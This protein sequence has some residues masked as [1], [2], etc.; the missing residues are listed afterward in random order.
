MKIKV[1]NIRLSKEYYLKDQEKLNEFLKDV[2]IKKSSTAFVEGN[3]NFWSIIF[4]YEELPIK[5]VEPLI[6]DFKNSENSLEELS[7]VEYQ[8]LLRLKDWRTRQGEKERLPLFMIMT[9]ENLV[10]IA[11]HK[12]QKLE[13]FFQLKGFGEKKINRY[14]IDILKIIHNFKE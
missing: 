1:F 7:K 3:I 11:R 13:D 10:Q 2:N 4:H 5:K 9:N 12:P 6:P 14:A 8:L